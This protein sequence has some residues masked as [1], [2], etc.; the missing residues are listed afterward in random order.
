MS[1]LLDTHAALWL[2]QGDERLSGSARTA[3]EEL[4]HDEICVSDLLLLELGLLVAKQRVVIDEPL[5]GFLEDFVAHFHVLP[6][7][8]R[9]AS[10]AVEL[11][12]PQADPFDRIF[13]ATAIRH[14]LPL[15][16]RDRGIRE[17]GLVKT[18]W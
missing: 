8:A 9:I 13:V 4:E 15:V 10:A 1:L 18:I 14:R 5:G 16:T 2:V 17:S 11:G 3:I 7:D 6:V 12:L